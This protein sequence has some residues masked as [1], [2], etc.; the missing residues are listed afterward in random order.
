MPKLP[1][2]FCVMCLY[3]ALFD[4]T[5]P[6]KHQFLHGEPIIL[7]DMTQQTAVYPTLDDFW[8]GR[9]EWV[10]NR[11]DVGLPIGESDTIHLGS[12]NYRSYLHA[13]YQ[14]AGV[15]DSC[16]EPVAFP[17]CLTVW[18]ST[19]GGN[20][21]SIASGVCLIPCTQCPCDDQRDHHGNTIH[22]TRAAAQQYPRATY[23]GEMW[24][25]AYEWHSQV[26][27]RRSVD[28]LTWSD[29]RYL[30][31]PGGTYPSSLSACSPWEQ[32][33]AHPNIRG[34]AEDCLV[35]APPGIYIE[36]DVLYVFVASGS[37]PS[38]MRCYFGDKRADLGQLRL[39]NTDPLFSGAPTYGDVSVF[40]AD[41]NAYFDFRYIS[42]AEVMKV[43]ERYYLFYEGIRGPSELE[44]GRDNQ[45]GLGLARTVGDAID[46]EWEKFPQ[47]PILD[48]MVD[49]WG[50]GHADVLVINGQ[51]VMYTA[52]SQTTRGKYVLAWK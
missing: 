47:N 41:A 7:M 1:F 28:G 8:D 2:L 18:N 10:M 37:A 29:W 19:D 31:V 49:N 33:G 23:D 14:S 51:T 5:L 16:G 45:F 20:L 15:V 21:F 35:G 4:F 48:D 43:G 50:I 11:E 17:G 38:N 52:T 42:S 22:D 44:F 12:G 13:S 34:Q 24:Y 27:L 26:I 30:V 32:I 46:G 39:C 6:P 40:G 9:A 36:G 3:V 25:M